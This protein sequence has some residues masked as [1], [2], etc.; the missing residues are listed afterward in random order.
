MAETTEDFR[1][2]IRWYSQIVRYLLNRSDGLPGAVVQLIRDANTERHQKWGM[3]GDE[4]EEE[5]S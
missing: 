3:A 2:I 5:E 1:S 4:N